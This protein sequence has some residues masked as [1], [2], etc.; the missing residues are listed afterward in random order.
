MV[1]CSAARQPPHHMDAMLLHVGGIDLLH[2]VLVFPDNYGGLINIEE[3][4]VL[5][6]T[7]LLQRIFLQGQIDRRI[8]N[9]F[10][11]NE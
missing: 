1:H 4:E 7:D 5:P 3:Q 6:G 10:V 9:A 11:V 8:G 2:R